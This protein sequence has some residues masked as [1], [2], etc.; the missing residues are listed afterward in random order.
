MSKPSH[1]LPNSIKDAPT[2]L[3]SSENGSAATTLLELRAPVWRQGQ[4]GGG[5][6]NVEGEQNVLKM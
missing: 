2:T 1:V 5:R 6:E 4:Q 3:H